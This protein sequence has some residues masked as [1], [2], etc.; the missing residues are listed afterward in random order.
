MTSAPTST[1]FVFHERY[2]WHDTG[3]AAAFVSALECRY[4]EPD[5]HIESPGA[6]RR[7]RNLLE[8]TGLLA[9]L[10]PIPPRYA[11]VDELRRVHDRDYIERIR[12]LSEAGHGDAGVTA[13]IGPHSYDIARLAAGGVIT[14]LE[15]VVEGRV[16]NAYALVRPPGHH[17][18]PARGMG[19][20][21]FANIAV[22]IRHAQAVLGVGRVAVLDWDVHH[23]NGTETCFYG[24]ADVLTI[25]LHQDRNFP[26]HRGLVEHNGDG[27]GKGANINIPLPPGSGVGAYDDAFE[28]VVGPAVDRFQ[29]ELIVCASGYDGG[30]LD[31]MGR[32]MLHSD[33]YRGFTATARHL[34][35]RW[36]DGRLVVVHEGGYN[37]GHVPF[38]GLAVIE[39]LAG[40]RTD[41]VDPF[42][43]YAQRIGQQER[44]P[45]QAALVDRAAALI[46]R[47]P[48]PLVPSGRPGAPRA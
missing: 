30:I 14:A 19:F 41:C 22:A 18:E 37:P 39:E 6:K 46:D 24:D 35:D 34:A 28:R 1:G 33:A 36:C 44:Q 32:M 29:P 43:R 21:I 17:A 27:S 5:D 9:E 2:L 31:P 12:T 13:P 11:T 10:T 20:C 42:L 40:I 25:S 45:H 38:C 16:G 8:V 4:V 3:S 26:P 7:L 15:A 47:V 48:V 23:G